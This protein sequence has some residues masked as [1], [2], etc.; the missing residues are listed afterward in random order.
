AELS[1]Q[2]LTYSGLAEKKIEYVDLSELVGSMGRLLKVALPNNAQLHFDLASHLPAIEVDATQIRQVVMNMVT[3]ASDALG[4]KPGKISIRT[5][6]SFWKAEQI[7]Q[8]AVGSDLP[9]GNYLSCTIK[10][11][12]DGMGP[13]TIKNIFDPFFTTKFTGRGLGMATMLGR[14]K[15]HKGAIVVKSTEGVGTTMTVLLP[16][17]SEKREDNADVVA[18]DGSSELLFSEITAL[19]VDDE[20]MALELGKRMLAS[21]QVDFVAA[22]SGRKAIELFKNSQG[23]IDVIFLDI[24]MPAM[25]GIATAKAILEIDPKASIILLSGLGLNSIR[26]KSEG[27]KI[28]AMMAKPYRREEI[29]QALRDVLQ[30]KNRHQV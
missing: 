17:V 13:E 27:I 30:K 7:R 2:L 20:T 3:N 6:V 15:T 12:G 22:R 26:Q 24:T 1:R 14:I 18:Q 9:E 23:S 21:L 28:A 16:V 4:K 25:D 19:F 11:T 8:A 10:D 5:R 29:A